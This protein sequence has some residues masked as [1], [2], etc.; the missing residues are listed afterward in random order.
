MKIT[1]VKTDNIAPNKLAAPSQ[2]SACR[3]VV[4]NPC[5][6][7]ITIPNTNENTNEINKGL[8]KDSNFN[9]LRKNKNQTK[10]NTK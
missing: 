2:I 9:C 7:S 10:V 3:V 6:T 8:K 4:T 5:N 1:I